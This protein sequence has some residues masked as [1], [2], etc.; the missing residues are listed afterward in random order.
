MTYNYHIHTD[1]EV[2]EKGIPSQSIRDFDKNHLRTYLRLLEGEELE[3]DLSA[4]C[5]L[6]ID[7]D[8]RARANT[9]CLARKLKFT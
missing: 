6:Q 4:Y 1:F 7:A 8:Y 2:F 3:F 5:P 9:R